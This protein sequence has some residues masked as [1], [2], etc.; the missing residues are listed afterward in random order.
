MFPIIA[1]GQTLNIANDVQTAATLTNTTVTLTGRAELNI[2]GTGDPIPG[3]TIHLNSDDAWFFMRN[4]R[5]SAVNTTFLSRIRV[6]GANA[7]LNT[8]VRVVQYEKGTVVIPHGP[9][10]APMQVFDGANFTGP[11]KSLKLYTY[12]NEANLGILSAAASSFKL[13]RGYM[14]TIAQQNT[15]MGS[16][17]VYIAQD[18]DLEIGVLPAVLN[19]NIR[20]VRVFPWRWVLKKGW[21]GGDGWQMNH[22]WNYGWD[23]GGDSANLDSEYVPMRHGPYWPGF[24]EINAKQN[25]THLLGY[26]EPDNTWDAAQTPQ[27]VDQAIA[28]WPELM[29][30]GLRLGSP[31]VTDGGLDSWLYPFIDRCDQLGY[32]VDFVTVHFYRANYDAWGLHELLRTISERTH[33]PYPARSAPPAGGAPGGTAESEPPS[34]TRRMRQ[35]RSRPGSRPRR[36]APCLRGLSR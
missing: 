13:K 6:N 34:R 26:N 23:A 27:T 31:A 16:S 21:G 12:Y 33:R 22:Y 24:D 32:R 11:S 2:T 14:C 17:K 30:S 1:R 20:Y 15:G 8:N 4:I 5:P 35:C 10:F 9:N 18:G 7:V 29:K 25:V 36:T 19:N 3:C 28:Q